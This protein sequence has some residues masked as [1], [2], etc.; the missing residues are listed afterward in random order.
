[1]NDGPILWQLP[2][3]IRYCIV[4]KQSILC[5][6]SYA[7][8]RNAVTMLKA[9][10]SVFCFEFWQP[11][12]LLHLLAIP[13]A[14]FSFPLFLCASSGTMDSPFESSFACAVILQFGQ[15]QY[16]PS[17]DRTSSRVKKL[18]PKKELALRLQT[19]PC[20]QAKC[21]AVFTPEKAFKSLLALLLAI[22]Q[23]I[24]N[25]HTASCFP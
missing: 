24:Q 14:P 21:E 6:I 1:M 5:R 9:A 4:S 8:R 23:K 7:S 15:L 3:T 10:I 25:W 2:K 11:F 19:T 13:V 17:K 20:S 16:L 22:P 18:D 12:R